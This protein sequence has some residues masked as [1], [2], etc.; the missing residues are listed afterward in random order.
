M[1]PHDHD[2]RELL[3]TAAAVD[4]VASGL[5]RLEEGRARELVRAMRGSL[6]DVAERLT[7]VAARLPSD[8]K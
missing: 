2:R 6:R 3:R 5:L 4:R 8:D 7:T 1:A